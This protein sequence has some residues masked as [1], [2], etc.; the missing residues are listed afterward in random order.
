VVAQ[1]KPQFNGFIL[2]CYEEII[3]LRKEKS[4]IG[5]LNY[6]YYWDL[7]FFIYIMI[8]LVVSGAIILVSI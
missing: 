7:I 3:E 1:K 4:L 2:K 6:F 8:I 5:T